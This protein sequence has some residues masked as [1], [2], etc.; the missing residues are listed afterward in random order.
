MFGAVV[1]TVVLFLALVDDLADTN[2]GLYSI[3]PVRATLQNALLA[4]ADSMLERGN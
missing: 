2:T 4:K 3:A 1:G